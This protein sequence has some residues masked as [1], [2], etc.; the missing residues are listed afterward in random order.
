MLIGAN[1]QIFDTDFHPLE[2]RYRVG[3]ERDD[4][5]SRKKQIIIEDDCFIGAGTII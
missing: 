3:E 4:V 1:C 5:F 2:A